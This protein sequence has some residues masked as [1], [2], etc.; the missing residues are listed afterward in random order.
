MTLTNKDALIKEVQKL[1]VAHHSKK[2][3]M[4]LTNEQLIEIIL[5]KKSLYA[6]ISYSKLLKE[7]K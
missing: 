3:L 1:S 6:G 7:K 5:F 2:D 4:R